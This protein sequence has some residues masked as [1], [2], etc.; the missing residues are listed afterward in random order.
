MLRAS[1]STSTE[2]RLNVSDETGVV[3]A[4]STQINQ[5]LINLCT[6]A[7][8]AMPDGGIIDITLSKTQIDEKQTIKMGVADYIEKPFDQRDFA[9]KVRK[10]LDEK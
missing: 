8:H 3:L 6:N 2:I 5:V 10:V 7:Q 9:L 1:I 4:D